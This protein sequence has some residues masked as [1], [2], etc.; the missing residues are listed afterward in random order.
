MWKVH[1]LVGK[2][3]SGIGD[4][5]SGAGNQ[6]LVPYLSKRLGYFKT[7]NREQGIGNGNLELVPFPYFGGS[8]RRLTSANR[9]EGISSQFL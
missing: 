1:I 2:C 6:F 4:R 5:E 3:E 9:D 8:Y 7:V